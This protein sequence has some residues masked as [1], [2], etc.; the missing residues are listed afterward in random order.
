MSYLVYPQCPPLLGYVGYIYVY[1]PRE[2]KIPCNALNEGGT[3]ISTMNPSK[4]R[5]NNVKL[6]DILNACSP[7]V[8]SDAIVMVENALFSPSSHSDQVIQASSHPNGIFDPP[9]VSIVFTL[10][11]S[12]KHGSFIPPLWFTKY[13]GAIHR[14]SSGKLCSSQWYCRGA[15]RGRSFQYP[16]E[17]SRISVLDNMY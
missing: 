11:N 16:G 6:R 10:Y 12:R 4:Q 1:A 14:L 2:R 13:G 9:K 15:V 8:V 7:L 3:F 17:R 5:N